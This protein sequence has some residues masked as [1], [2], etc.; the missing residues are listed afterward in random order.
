MTQLGNSGST[1]ENLQRS[2]PSGWIPISWS[3]QQRQIFTNR[4]G[5]LRS[6][7]DKIGASKTDLALTTKPSEVQAP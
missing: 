7:R 6:S 1:S 2:R 5:S 4:N 3:K